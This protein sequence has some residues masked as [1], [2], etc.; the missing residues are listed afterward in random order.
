VEGSCADILRSWDRRK[1]AEQRRQV[2]R[3]T[4]SLRGGRGRGAAGRGRWEQRGTAALRGGRGG[5]RPA[6]HT[7]S[8]ALEGAGVQYNDRH[9]PGRGQ[10]APASSYS[11]GSWQPASLASEPSLTPSAT[12]AVTT[13]RGWYPAAEASSAITSSMAAGWTIP[14]PPGPRQHPTSS[15][16]THRQ[17]C[18]AQHAEPQQGWDAHAQAA[19][20]APKA[21]STDNEMHDMLALLGI[22]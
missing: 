12:P 6:R 13:S 21:R 16:S 19:G 14:P 3:A 18:T 11:A 1:L 22:V 20:A 10:A 15:S 17:E 8:I 5:G 7:P 4:A 9:V 2:E